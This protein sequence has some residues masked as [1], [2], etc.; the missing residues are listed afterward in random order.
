MGCFEGFDDGTEA[1]AFAWVMTFFGGLL[2]GTAAWIG[3]IR[4]LDPGSRRE[5]RRRIAVRR[6]RQAPLAAVEL[7]HAAL[8]AAAVRSTAEPVRPRTPAP[9]VDGRGRLAWW[10]NRDLL[11]AFGLPQIAA[12]TVFTALAGF[13]GVLHI[14]GGVTHG[15]FFLVCSVGGLVAVAM[16]SRLARGVAGVAD[17]EQVRPM[18][19]LLLREPDGGEAYMVLYP[20]DGDPDQA[21]PMLLR[22]AKKRQARR[23]PSAGVADVRGLLRPRT[24]LV[25]WIDGS[26]VWTRDPVTALDLTTERDRAR[27]T[28]LKGSEADGRGTTS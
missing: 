5:R 28:Y 1:G 10:R 12:W 17:S 27:L 23:L 11:A 13:A 19:W 7:T 4:R 25:P 14:F 6:S 16:E 15:Y 21:P 26:P 18:R 22:L 8:L 3:L 9:V 2:M 20:A 24:V